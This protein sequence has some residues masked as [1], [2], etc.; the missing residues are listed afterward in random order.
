MVKDEVFQEF[1]EE[2]KDVDIAGETPDTGAELT[3]TLVLLTTSLLVIAIIVMEL[4]LKKWFA[5]GLF[6]SSPPGA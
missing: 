3:S 2:L 6:A 5:A 1:T 4:A